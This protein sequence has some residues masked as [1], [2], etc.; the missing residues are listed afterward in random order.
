[1]SVFSE[2]SEDINGYLYLKSLEIGGHHR[3]YTYVYT[4]MYTH[5]HRHKKESWL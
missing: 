3:I 5:K 2:G 1:L 4:H